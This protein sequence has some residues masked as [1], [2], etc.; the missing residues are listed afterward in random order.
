MPTVLVS[1]LVMVP[2]ALKLQPLLLLHWVDELIGE[3]PVEQSIS[4]LCSWQVFL[5]LTKLNRGFQ[6]LN[7]DE[8]VVMPLRTAVSLPSPGFTPSSKNH[9]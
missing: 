4:E 5:F 9:F 1:P 6:Q 3:Q 8:L 2:L 7:V